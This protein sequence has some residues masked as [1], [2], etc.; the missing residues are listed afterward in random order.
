MASEEGKIGI[1][2]FNGTDFGLS[3]SKS[4]AH[5]VV[6]KKT[7]AGLMAALS[8]KSKLSYEG[9]RDLIFNEEV[10]RRDAGEASCSGVALKLETRGKGQDRNSGQGKQKKA[11]FTEVGKAPKLVKLELIHTDLWG[12]ALVASLRGSRY[13][14]T[15]IDDSS[16]KWILHDWGDKECIQILKKCREAILEEKGKAIIVEAVIEEEGKMDELSDARLALDMAMMAH[17]NAGKERTLKEWKFLLEKVG[18]T[19]YTVKSIHA[20][21]SV[22]KAFP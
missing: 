15:F 5:N 17:T 7:I 11:S 4:V 16:R 9:I 12:P 6:K 18:F 10:R 8:R 13:Y 14:I 21:Q 3:L 20:V 22:I 1:E 2:K 19:R